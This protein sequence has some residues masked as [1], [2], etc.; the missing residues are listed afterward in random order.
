MSDIVYSCDDFVSIATNRVR[1]Y[2]MLSLVYP[3]VVSANHSSLIKLHYK[4]YLLYVTLPQICSSRSY[5]K[6]VI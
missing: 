2:N 1:H 6:L 5:S 4:V 3:W